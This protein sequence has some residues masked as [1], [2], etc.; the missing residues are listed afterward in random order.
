MSDQHSSPTN[1]VRMTFPSTQDHP[2]IS[3][4]NSPNPRVF[5]FSDNAQRSLPSLSPIPPDF[6]PRDIPSPLNS[7]PP[8]RSPR[9]SPHQEDG[10]ANLM[11]GLQFEGQDRDQTI[12]SHSQ[13]IANL[14]TQ[15][16][17]Q[18]EILRRND[19]TIKELRQLLVFAADV[20]NMKAQYPKDLKTVRD[21]VDGALNTFHMRVSHLENR[22]DPSPVAKV[23]PEPPFYSHIYF[24]GDIAETHRFCCLIR[25]TFA[26][27]PGHF[28]SERQRILWISGYFRTASGNLG[29]DCPSYTW[30]R[31]LL[32]KN[33]HEQGLPTQKASS[34]ADF[35]I[36]ELYDS[37]SFLSAIED[38][39]SNHKEA[40]EQRKALF[41][42]RQGN[43]SIA[44]F[45]IQFNTL[46][47]TVVLSEES[48]CEV[49]EAAINPKIVELGVNR[50]GWTELDNLVDKQRMAVRLS[51][52][53]L[54]VSQLNQRKNYNP[55]P[56]IEFKQ[57]T[58]PQYQ[59]P[60]PHID[61]KRTSISPAQAKPFVTF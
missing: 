31:G 55:L 37:E 54:R 39:F 61:F 50:G 26:R 49:Y 13:A 56:R 41:A 20:N 19:E 6:Q 17:R 48:K 10:M 2:L 22:P 46:L 44:E 60:L 15:A 28:S 35:V 11:S 12:L 16:R 33:A 53:V 58:I 45:N 8:N 9:L 14:E 40:E 21:S 59:K 29:A 52:D 23:F 25:D 3:P 1:P 18:E 47:Y 34:T 43:K 27:I 4:F 57:A 5:I 42:L 7:S 30:W 38:M 24:S 51:I 32:T 36:D